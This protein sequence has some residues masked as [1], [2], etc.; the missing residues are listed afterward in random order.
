MR[1]HFASVPPGFLVPGSLPDP[2]TGPD[3]ATAA[4]GP[5]ARSPGGSVP[6]KV[7]QTAAPTA[8]RNIPRPRISP[9][10]DPE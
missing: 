3:N 10:G 6:D 7:R 5:A 4:P 9:D 8:G 1:M 2:A